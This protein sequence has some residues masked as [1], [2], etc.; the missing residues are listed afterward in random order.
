MSPRP[1]WKNPRKSV[2]SSDLE[3]RSLGVGDPNSPEKASGKSKARWS[4][5]DLTGG[6][7]TPGA[8]KEYDVGHDLGQ[9]PTLCTLETYTNSAV[10]GTFIEATEARR[11]NWSPSH[12]HVSVRL[13]A[14]SLDGCVASFRVQGR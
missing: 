9:V 6:G 1:A 4:R 3:D 12:C 13:I 8:I 11:E 7:S 5:V 14:G 10:A 2:Q